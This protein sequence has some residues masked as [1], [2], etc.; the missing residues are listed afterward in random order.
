M[1]PERDELK[2]TF[3]SNWPNCNDQRYQIWRFIT[4]GFVH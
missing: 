3:V 4:S 1:N 2:L